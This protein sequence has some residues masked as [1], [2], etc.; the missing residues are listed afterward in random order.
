MSLIT[1]LIFPSATQTTQPRSTPGSSVDSAAKAFGE[2]LTSLIEDADAKQ[3]TAESQIRERAAGE[4]DLVQTMVALSD[5]DLSLRMIVNVRN[6]ALE[7]YQE[8]MRMPV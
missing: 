1:D 5:A 2:G 3:K 4:G 7:A 8:I 6:R